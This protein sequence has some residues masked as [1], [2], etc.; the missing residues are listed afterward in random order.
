M[1]TL[2]N[3]PAYSF[4]KQGKEQTLTSRTPGP[5]DYDWHLSKI[6]TMKKSPGIL[7]PQAII[8]GHQNINGYFNNNAAK[9]DDRD[10]N[11]PIDFPIKGFGF[12]KTEKSKTTRD[13]SNSFILFRICFWVQN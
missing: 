4:G 1:I 8:N 9:T 12:G 10:Y 6:K 5:S 7:I 3:V 13:Q 2:P 11:P